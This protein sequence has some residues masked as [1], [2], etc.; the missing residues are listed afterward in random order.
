MAYVTYAAVSLN[1]DTDCNPTLSTEK[2]Y[3]VGPQ[4][5]G[6][7]LAFLSILW[8]SVMTT[9]RMAHVMGAGG[10][11]NSGM[12]NVGS[13]SH[14]GARTSST[15]EALQTSLRVTVMNLNVIF[16]A[17]AFYVAM[18]LTNW[19]TIVVDE[20]SSSPNGGSVSMW[21]QAVGGWIAVGMYIVGLILPK[22]RIL[23]RSIWDLQPQ[24]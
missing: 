11:T 12:L 21:M 13:G 20:D 15:K 23:P 19:G 5:I 18:I 22:F 2:V 1:P 4:V 10:I 17:L 6:L 8:V 9:R 3:G 16:A 24:F 7:V 14:S